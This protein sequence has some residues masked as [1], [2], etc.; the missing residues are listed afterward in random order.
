MPLGSHTPSGWGLRGWLPGALSDSSRVEV[1]GQMAIVAYFHD[2]AIFYHGVTWRLRICGEQGSKTR[3]AGLTI[4]W[5]QRKG[6]V[7][8]RRSASEHRLTG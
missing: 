5:S 2:R 4:K 1:E 8:S 7:T 6:I 3:R